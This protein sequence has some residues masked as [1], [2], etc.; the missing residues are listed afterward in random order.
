MKTSGCLIAAMFLLFASSS[1]SSYVIDGEQVWWQ[2]SNFH[3]TCDKNGTHP[4]IQS[5]VCEHTYI[6]AE[7]S[8]TLND[9]YVY[10]SSKLTPYYVDY[11]RNW[12]HVG[13]QQQTVNSSESILVTGYTNVSL[14]NASCDWGD[15]DS[16]NR[17]NVTWNHGNGSDPE[18]I[19]YCF[20][21]ITNNSGDY[22]LTHSIAVEL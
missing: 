17:H 5:Q 21:G 18:S 13:Q 10:D 11:W 20:D 1:Y 4:R 8:I 22:T 7:D 15:E 12:S 3:V 6:G 14:T 19:V 2:N 9:T 16:N